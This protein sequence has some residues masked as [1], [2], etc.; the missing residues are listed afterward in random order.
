MKTIVLIS[1]CGPKLKVRS[2][3]KDI[4]I[5]TRF[6]YSLQ[7]A[8]RLKPNNILILSSKYGLLNMY[9]EIEP[10]DETLNTKSVLDIIRWSTNIVLELR[11]V[12][13]LQNDL[14]IFLAGI[15]YRKYV[16]PYIKNY[17]IPLKGLKI[18]QQL[19]KLKLDV[20]GHAPV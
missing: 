20:S 11:K 19:K 7:Y 5:S 15:K 16:L 9:K 3:A 13:D 1:C 8:K 4:Y 10:Y 14:F 17:R 6:K 18:G 2:R 12:A